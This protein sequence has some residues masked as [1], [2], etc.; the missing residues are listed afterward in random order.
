MLEPEIEREETE[1]SES[2][3]REKIRKIIEINLENL[4]DEENEISDEIFLEEESEEDNEVFNPLFKPE[5]GQTF[6]DRLSELLSKDDDDENQSSFHFEGQEILR[7][8]ADFENKKENEPFETDRRTLSDILTRADLLDDGNDF[9]F[10][11]ENGSERENYLFDVVEDAEYTSLEDKNDDLDEDDYEKQFVDEEL[12]ETKSEAELIADE[13]ALIL[14]RLQADQKEE[15]DLM[16]ETYRIIRSRL[17]HKSTK[18]LLEDE[19]FIN[20][21]FYRFAIMR[22]PLRPEDIPVSELAEIKN[23]VRSSLASVMEDTKELLRELR[24]DIIEEDEVDEEERAKR[25]D[26]AK[27]KLQKLL[28]IISSQQ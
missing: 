20:S 27:R 16:L 25:I 17:K 23:V 6:L 22:L 19:E 21:V 24:R 11:L 14:V 5:P 12:E 9:D 7:N 13:L 10:L 28:E 2:V 4:R 26:I 15:T 3:L 8:F 18:R 1:D